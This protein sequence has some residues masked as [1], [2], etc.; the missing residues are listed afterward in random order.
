[1]PKPLYLC[2]NNN[3]DSKKNV[4]ELFRNTGPEESTEK[5]KVFYDNYQKNHQTIATRV[6]IQSPIQ[7]SSGFFNE[8]C[9]IKVA[10]SVSKKRHHVTTK[11]AFLKELALL[12]P[13]KNLNEFVD[14]HLLKATEK[15][16]TNRVMNQKNLC[17]IQPSKLSPESPEHENEGLLKGIYAFVYLIIFTALNL[18]YKCV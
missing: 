7:L 16:L 15:R 9:L 13:L 11:T 18:E 17:K 1:M 14:S 12:E 3:Q 5:V 10:Q 4:V 2:E 6:S 8:N